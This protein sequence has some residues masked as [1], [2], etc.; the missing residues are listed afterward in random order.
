MNAKQL[1]RIILKDGWL[2]K[3]QKGSHQQFV[4]PTK[5]GKVTISIHGKKDIKLNTLKSI[6]KQAGLNIK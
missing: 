3:T 4:H 1:E 2:L 6:L 5:K